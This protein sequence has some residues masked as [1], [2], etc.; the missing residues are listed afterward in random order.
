MARTDGH[1]E[2]EVVNHVGLT[3][4]LVE[5]ILRSPDTIDREM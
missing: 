3:V 1:G 2:A 5:R 4:A